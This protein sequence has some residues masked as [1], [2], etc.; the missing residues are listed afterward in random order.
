MADL[1]KEATGFEAVSRESVYAPPRLQALG[2]LR[3]LTRNEIP[4]TGGGELGPART[5]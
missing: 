2:S 3:E 4:E 1:S 5:F